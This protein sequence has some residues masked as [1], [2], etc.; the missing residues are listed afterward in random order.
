VILNGFIIHLSWHIH[1]IWRT[2]KCIH[3][4]TPANFFSVKCVWFLSQ[5][6]S[7]SPTM[8]NTAQNFRR[9]TTI[10]EHWQNISED[11][12]IISEHCRWFLKIFWLFPTITDNFRRC[13]DDLL[14]SNKPSSTTFTIILLHYFLLKANWI[15]HAFGSVEEVV[16]IWKQL[17]KICLCAWD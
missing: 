13:L 1:G 12:P 4:C 8:S 11:V 9:F 15:L 14:T 5:N 2:R 3:T 10:S 7:D 6:H 17:W 16:Q